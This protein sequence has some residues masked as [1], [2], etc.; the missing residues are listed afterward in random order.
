MKTQEIIGEI[1]KTRDSK[2]ITSFFF[3]FLPDR[4]FFPKTN[5][6]MRQITQPYKEVFFL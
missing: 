6:K 2:V 1:E 5:R 4:S 3:F